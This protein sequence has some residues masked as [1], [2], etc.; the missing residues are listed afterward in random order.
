MLA[1]P[2]PQKGGAGCPVLEG[3]PCPL[4]ANAD[5]IVFALDPADAASADVLAGHRDVHPGVPLC[6]D[7]GAMTPDDLIA[8]VEQLAGGEVSG[9]TDPARPTRSPLDVARFGD[10]ERFLGGRGSAPGRAQAHGRATP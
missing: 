6:V 3:K 5:V 9:E 7:T 4:A 8:M 2:G 1:C 10:G